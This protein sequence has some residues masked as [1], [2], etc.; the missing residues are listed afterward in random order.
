MLN[1]KLQNALDITSGK[2]DLIVNFIQS[3][4][5]RVEQTKHFVN[6]GANSLYSHADYLACPFRG[7]REIM[8]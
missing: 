4:D 3:V 1:K 8:I 5:I 2:H 6:A 7:I